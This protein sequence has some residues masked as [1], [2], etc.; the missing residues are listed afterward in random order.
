MR[1]RFIEDHR[2]VFVVRVMCAVLEVSASGYYAWRRRADSARTQ[3]N[4]GR[5]ST[6]SAASSMPTA[7]PAPLRQPPRA[8]HAPGRGQPGGA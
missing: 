8:R 1:F 5:W 3:S 4:R 2:A 6:R 7:Q